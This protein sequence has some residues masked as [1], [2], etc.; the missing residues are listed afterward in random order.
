MPVA[1]KTS[2]DSYVV[3][4]LGAYS[5]LRNAATKAEDMSQ[6]MS[7]AEDVRARAGALSLDFGVQ[8]LQL[9]AAHEAFMSQFT[10]I[11][12]PPQ[13]VV[14]QAIADAKQ[15]AN[16]VA[17][18]LLAEGKLEAVIGVI[19]ALNELGT[20][21]PGAGVQANSPQMAVLM[22]AHLQ[23]TTSAWLKSVRAVAP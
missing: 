3:S 11:N 13:S 16:L 19:G 10:G 15:L 9:K 20:K 8:L 4:Y 5:G 6:D 2:L 12:P 23:R 1:D 7:L 17:N 22:D 21:A 18:N 14:D